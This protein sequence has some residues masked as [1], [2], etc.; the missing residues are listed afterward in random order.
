[1]WP[2]PTASDAG[3]FPDLILADGEIRLTGPADAHEESGGQYALNT[4][5]RVWTMLWLMMLAMGWKAGLAAGSSPPL[6]VSFRHG[7][8]SWSE[9]LVSN[10]AFYELMMGWPIGWTAPEEPVTEFAAWLQ[11]SRGAFLRAITSFEAPSKV[12]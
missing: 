2:T 9:T 1:M 4:A 12:T 10:P 3:Y 8:N 5:A 6:R 7:R 11:L